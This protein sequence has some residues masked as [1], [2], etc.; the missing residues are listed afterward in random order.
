VEVD[1]EPAPMPRDASAPASKVEDR[2][3]CYGATSMLIEKA[4][5]ELRV[6]LTALQEGVEVTEA[7]PDPHPQLGGWNR[8]PIR[9]DMAA[10][11]ECAAHT[12]NGLVQG[13][14]W[15]E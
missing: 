7:R 3:G 14:D 8:K 11:S 15:R 4:A 9:I 10:A 12:E 6:S 2:R 13:D 1:V 5:Y